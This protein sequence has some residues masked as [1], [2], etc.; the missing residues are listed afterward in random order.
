MAAKDNGSSY[1]RVASRSNVF[2]AATLYA[3]NKAVPI[4]IRNLSDHGAMLEGASLPG[5]GEKVQLQRGS[6]S[7]TAQVAWQRDQFRGVWFDDPI[8]VA[9]WVKAVG[10]SGQ[11]RVDMVLSALRQKPVRQPHTLPSAG[12]PDAL[13]TLGA[14]L[15]G[16][17]ERLAALPNMSVQLAEELLKLDGVAQSLMKVGQA[18]TGEG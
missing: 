5:E 6:L 4:R 1:T 12:S 13:T 2:L 11:R 7:A 9:F 3:Q 15:Q 18:R 16:I 10:H 8:E 14:E 17:C